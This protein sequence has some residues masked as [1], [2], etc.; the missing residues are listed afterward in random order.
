MNL[1]KN[2]SGYRASNAVAA[3]TSTING[4]AIDMQNYNGV[5]FL[6]AFGAIT[7]GAVT[8]IKAQ[9]GAASDGSDATDLA[10]TAI[11]VADTDDNKVFLLDVYLPGYRYVRPVVLR[12]TQ[13]AVVD[14]ITAIRYDGRNRPT[15]HDGT[16]FGT[17]KLVVS[18]AA[19]TP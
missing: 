11:T 17:A 13:N 18:P 15:A 9:G 16:T 1:S 12:A 14:S 19:G 3:G 2:V 8:S 4:T 5:M 10:G 6:I 7:S